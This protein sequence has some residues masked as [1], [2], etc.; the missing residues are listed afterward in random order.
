MR[1]IAGA[2]LVALGQLLPPA[3][4]R[5]GLGTFALLP[6]RLAFSALAFIIANT[7]L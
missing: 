6:I 2:N 7:M 5:A 4:E 3:Q 1:T